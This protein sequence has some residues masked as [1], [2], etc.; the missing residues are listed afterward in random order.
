M[1]HVSR[2]ATELAQKMASP[3]IDG[4]AYKARLRRSSM[5]DDDTPARVRW[6][7][8]RFAIIG[9]LLSDVRECMQARAAGFNFSE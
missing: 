7:R 5:T 9:P 2:G 4:A 3:L 6:A 1:R 8:L